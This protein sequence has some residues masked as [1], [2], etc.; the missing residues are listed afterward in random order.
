MALRQA[1]IIFLRA[2]DEYLGLKQTIPPSK[3]Q[4]RRKENK[5]VE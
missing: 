4:K 3:G 1:I 2:L 5:Q